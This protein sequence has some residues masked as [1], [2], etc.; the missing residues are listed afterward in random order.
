MYVLSGHVSQ[1]ESGWGLL[2]WGLLLTIPTVLARSLLHLASV[3][4]FAH[5]HTQWREYISS[6]ASSIP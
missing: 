6:S 1:L 4:R 2:G 5:S 3:S